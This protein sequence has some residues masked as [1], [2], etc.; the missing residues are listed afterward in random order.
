LPPVVAHRFGQQP[1]DLVGARELVEILH[2]AAWNA[3]RDAPAR[4]SAPAQAA[5][6]DRIAGIGGRV[7]IAQL[8]VTTSGRRC[9]DQ[10]R[11]AGAGGRVPVAL[12]DPAP[13]GR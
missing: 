12:D 2:V 10:W 5:Q 11:Q 1:H 3:Q 4:P 8:R 13:A 6:R 9:A 7:A